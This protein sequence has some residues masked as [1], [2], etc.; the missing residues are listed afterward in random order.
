MLKEGADSQLEAFTSYEEQCSPRFCG[1]LVKPGEQASFPEVLLGDEKAVFNGAVWQ[2]TIDG[3]VRRFC[4]PRDMTHEQK[5]GVTDGTDRFDVLEWN[6][7]GFV[8]AKA[9][10][11]IPAEVVK[12]TAK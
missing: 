4:L 9:I 8:H 7:E 3:Q 10:S 6:F 1:M 5:P 12:G 2:Q 11:H